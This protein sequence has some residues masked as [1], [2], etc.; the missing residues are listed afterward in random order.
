MN[1]I[2]ELLAQIPMLRRT[3][4]EVAQFYLFAVCH[5]AQW[6][7]RDSSGCVWSAA[8]PKALVSEPMSRGYKPVRCGRSSLGSGQLP[9]GNASR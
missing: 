2:K 9:R 1:E 5:R 7:D 8:S 6:P 3:I 4:R